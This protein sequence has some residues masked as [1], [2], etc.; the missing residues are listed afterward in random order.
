VKLDAGSIERLVRGYLSWNRIDLCIAL[1]AR[2]DELG[3]PVSA[4]FPKIKGLA[5]VPGRYIGAFGKAVPARMNGQLVVSSPHDIVPHRGAVLAFLRGATGSAFTGVVRIGTKKVN[6][7][8]KRMRPK[9]FLLP[10][11]AAELNRVGQVTGKAYA[12]TPHAKPV[13][14]IYGRSVRGAITHL[15]TEVKAVR[16][17]GGW[18]RNPNGAGFVESQGTYSH[19]EVATSAQVASHAQLVSVI[20][21]KE[22]YR[23][24][25]QDKGDFVGFTVCKGHVGANGAVELANRYSTTSRGSNTFAFGELKGD[26]SYAQLY[27]TERWRDGIMAA[28][29]QLLQAQADLVRSG[30]NL[31]DYATWLAFGSGKKNAKWQSMKEKYWPSAF[32]AAGQDAL[33]ED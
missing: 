15:K 10:V 29:D 6:G 14:G 11:Q 12:P 9:M 25:A 13:T 24:L 26:V 30:T 33:H 8:A 32:R 19:H 18:Q 1:K 23:H 31:D 16:V 27:T 17:G 5:S 7:Q 3:G 4:L 20:R 28:C 21:D 2:L 22:Q